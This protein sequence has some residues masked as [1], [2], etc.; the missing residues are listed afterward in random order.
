M[1][2]DDTVKP[3][4]RDP[5]LQKSRFTR[6]Q[7]A[8]CGAQLLLKYAHRT[9]C[10]RYACLKAAA[11]KRRARHADGSADDAFVAVL[12]MHFCDPNQL[13]AT[14][15]R[16]KLAAAN[17]ALGNRKPTLPGRGTCVRET[18]LRPFGKN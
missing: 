6:G 16:N 10:C 11:A 9:M 8:T 13:I 18:V 2:L 12:G 15:Q 17:K 3:G 14:K 1:N 7:C 4:C 5:Y